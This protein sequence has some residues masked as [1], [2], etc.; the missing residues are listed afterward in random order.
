MKFKKCT[1]LL[2]ALLLL[3]SNMGLAFNVHFCEGRI[4]SVSSIFTVEEVCEMKAQPAEKGCC[5]QKSKSH[6]DCCK[7]KLVDLQDDSQEVIIKTV[8]FQFDMT[9]V[10]PEWKPFVFAKVT[11]VKKNEILTYCCDANAPPLYKR[12][13][14]YIFYA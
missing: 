13:H 5:A 9:S 2:L 10:L 7:D 4:A 3:V 12:Y 14:Q 8:T 1:S 11:A 6:K